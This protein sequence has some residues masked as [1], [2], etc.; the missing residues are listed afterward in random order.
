V[1][2]GY[3]CKNGGINIKP[4]KFDVAFT[5]VIASDNEAEMDVAIT[6][7]QITPDG[8][9]INVYILNAYPGYEAY[10][11]YTI[12]NKGEIPARFDSLTIKN[13]NPEALKITTTDHTYTWLQPGQTVQGTTTIQILEEADE[14]QQYS[15]EII[16]G[17]SSKEEK[18]R[19]V[20]FWTQQFSAA[21]TQTESQLQ[22]APETLENWLDQIS[23]KSSVMKFTGSKEEKFQQALNILQM[24][25]RPRMEDKLKAQLLA[26]WL[27]YIARWTEGYTLNGMTAWQI[28]QGSENAL[29]NKQT[30]QYQYWKD[31]CES[32]NK[33]G[34][35]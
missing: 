33:L 32:F 23:A 17:L 13:P 3:A 25:N 12:Q 30:T 11:T 22:I 2:Y 5:N 7:A 35:K 15:F 34:E 26:L 29:L 19:T 14:N 18:P 27:N 28:I 8:N 20:G 9:T 24:Q 21:L 16:M 4:N 10:I 6:S 31:L 1:G